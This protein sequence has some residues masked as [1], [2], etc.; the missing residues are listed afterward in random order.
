MAPSFAIPRPVSSFAGKHG[1][2][3]IGF[4]DAI[5]ADFFAKNL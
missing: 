3:L 4:R 1:L 2:N 5:R